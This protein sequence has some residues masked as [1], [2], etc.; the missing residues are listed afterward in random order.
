MRL[1]SGAGIAFAAVLN[2]LVILSAVSVSRSEADSESKDPYDSCAAVK[3]LGCFGSFVV[4]FVN[5][6]LAQH[7]IGF[8]VLT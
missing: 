4:P 2:A 3:L 7:D 1:G 6:S 8:Q 5:V